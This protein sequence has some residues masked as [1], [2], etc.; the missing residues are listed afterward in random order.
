LFRVLYS[1]W[2]KKKKQGGGKGG[3]VDGDAGEERGSFN[4]GV[5]Q[6]Q[7]WVKTSLENIIANP[8][9]RLLHCG[10]S[11]G[12]QDKGRNKREDE[13]SSGIAKILPERKRRETERS[14][15]SDIS[16]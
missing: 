11:H 5:K 1:G 12:R 9:S 8:A 14:G 3:I 10:S 16:I 15:S 6:I 13:S 4:K 7:T 2:K